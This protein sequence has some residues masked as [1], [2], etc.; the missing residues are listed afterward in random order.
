MQADFEDSLAP[1]WTNT[2]DG[3]I[4]LRDA[5]N[6]VIR[7]EDMARNKVYKLNDKTA[8]MFVRPRGWHLPGHMNAAHIYNYRTSF[9]YNIVHSFT[10]FNIFY[11]TFI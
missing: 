1:V 5:I 10:V 4:N 6:G 9:M 8:V 2:M 7:H 3:H 11:W